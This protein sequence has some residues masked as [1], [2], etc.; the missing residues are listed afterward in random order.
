MQDHQAFYW[1]KVR[2]GQK[3]PPFP[4]PHGLI[5]DENPL[6]EINVFSRSLPS[7]AHLYFLR[8]TSHLAAQWLMCN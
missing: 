5:L 6:D 2:D 8:R 1:D 7:P 3:V 4:S